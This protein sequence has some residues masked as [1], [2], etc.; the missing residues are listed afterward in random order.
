VGFSKNNFKE[1]YN[2]LSLYYI[3][4]LSDLLGFESAF[5]PLYRYIIKSHINL[6]ILYPCTGI[7]QAHRVPG[8]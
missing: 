5:L 8:K 1:Y 3:A 2:W 7:L 6:H 4:S